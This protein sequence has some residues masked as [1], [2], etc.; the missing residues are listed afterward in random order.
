MAYAVNQWKTELHD[1]IIPDYMGDIRSYKLIHGAD[2]TD[3]DMTNWERINE[4]RRSIAK[5]SLS[6]KG[7]LTRVKEAL[8][9]GDYQTASDLQVEL[10]GKM[11]LLRSMYVKYRK[12]L[13]CKKPGT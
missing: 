11:S 12:N 2:A 7:L 4:M 8:D 3:Y 6:S 5:D 10:Q 1:R 13:F 9:E